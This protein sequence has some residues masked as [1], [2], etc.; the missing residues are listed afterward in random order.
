VHVEPDLDVPDAE[1]RGGLPLPGQ[2]VATVLE[3]EVLPLPAGGGAA[4]KSY[5]RASQERVSRRCDLETMS[6][7]ESGTC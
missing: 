7:Q 6:S 4:R 1:D 2:L 5:S 3:A